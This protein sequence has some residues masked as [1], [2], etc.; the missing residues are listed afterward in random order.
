MRNP[1]PIG[2]FSV[3]SVLLQVVISGG[4]A[5]KLFCIISYK[6]RLQFFSVCNVAHKLEQLVKMCF[7][8]ENIPISKRGEPL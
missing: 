1:F 3:I 7:I 2:P 8:K 4:H 6:I 5:S